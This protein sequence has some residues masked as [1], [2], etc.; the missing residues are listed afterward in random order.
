MTGCPGYLCVTVNEWPTGNR[1]TRNDILVSCPSDFVLNFYIA[2]DGN[3]HQ[4]R[5]PDELL[6]EVPAEDDNDENS[7]D[8][9][10]Y[11]CLLDD[12]KVIHR[13]LLLHPKASASFTAPSS[14]N[15]DD[16]RQGSTS[17]PTSESLDGELPLRSIDDVNGSTA[18]VVVA[19]VMAIVSLRLCS[20]GLSCSSSAFVPFPAALLTKA[21]NK[22]R[23]K[24]NRRKSSAPSQRPTG[25]INGLNTALPA[26]TERRQASST[27]AFASAKH[28]RLRSSSNVRRQILITVYVMWKVLYSVSITLTVLSTVARIVVRKHY[29]DVTDTATEDSGHGHHRCPTRHSF[30][31][32]LNSKIGMNVADEVRMW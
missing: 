28:S 27:V 26:E 16:E 18:C 20:Y 17:K 15:T 8:D 32:R 31:D 12:A 25:A 6:S 29:L 22:L 4:L 5:D 24:R 7:P 30:V 19:V 2:R 10:V 14:R 3:K 23:N 9:H 13:F 11:E 1:L 21:G